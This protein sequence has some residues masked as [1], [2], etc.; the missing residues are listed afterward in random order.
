MTMSEV[1][2]T[3]R[4]KVS[5]DKATDK[6]NYRRKQHIPLEDLTTNSV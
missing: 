2:V 5:V 1:P 4:Y 3:V 6:S